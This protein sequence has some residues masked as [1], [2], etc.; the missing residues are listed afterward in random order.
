MNT[1]PMIAAGLV[2]TLAVWSIVFAI[3]FVSDEGDSDL[4]KYYSYTTFGVAPVV[5]A[6]CIW[7]IFACKGASK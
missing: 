5:A 7:L 6:V 2:A 4:T 1:V 3:L